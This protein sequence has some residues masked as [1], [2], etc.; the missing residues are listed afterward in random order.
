MPL[1]LH[2]LRHVSALAGFGAPLSETAVATPVEC[3]LPWICAL[4]RPGATA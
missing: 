3:V 4:Q 2:V 1:L